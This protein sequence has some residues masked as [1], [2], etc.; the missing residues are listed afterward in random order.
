MGLLLFCMHEYAVSSLIGEIVLMTISPLPTSLRV[1]VN[2][3]M[4][5]FRYDRRRQH[6]SLKQ[7][8]VR[9][10]LTRHK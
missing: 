8:L 1:R 10:G 5:S 6:Q 3:G 2:V 7:V 9:R 4:L